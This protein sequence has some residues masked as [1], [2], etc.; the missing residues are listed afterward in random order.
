MEK[1]ANL[2][3]TTISAINGWIKIV[4]LFTTFEFANPMQTVR[5]FNKKKNTIVK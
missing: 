2:D 4:L 1:N 5:R 3:D